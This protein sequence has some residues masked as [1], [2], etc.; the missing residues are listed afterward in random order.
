M[1]YSMKVKSVELHKKLGFEW[2]N[3][4]IVLALVSSIFEC[5]ISIANLIPQSKWGWSMEEAIKLYGLLC[6]VDIPLI[7]DVSAALMEIVCSLIELRRKQIPEQK[8]LTALLV[9]LAE[10]FGLKIS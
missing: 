3:D 8:H 2:A 5:V 7:P 1:R 6:G 9:I 4:D 10:R